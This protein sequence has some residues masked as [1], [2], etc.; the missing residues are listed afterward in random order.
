MLDSDQLND[1]SKAAIQTM[2]GLGVI[3]SDQGNKIHYSPP[4]TIT[5]AEAAVML[6][7][8]LIKLSCMNE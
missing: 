2:L 5:R 4:L 8:M 7:C 1:W 6:K 3:T